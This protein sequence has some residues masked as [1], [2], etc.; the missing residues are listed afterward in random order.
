MGSGRAAGSEVADDRTGETVPPPFL[1]VTTVQEVVERRPPPRFTPPVLL[2]PMTSYPGE[3]Y[4]VVLD[5]TAISPEI[6]TLAAE[7]TVVV[8]L[9]VLADGS[10]GRSEVV[11]SSGHPV[12]DQAAL[13]ASL[14]WRF[15]PATRDGRP[16]DAW[17]IVPVRFVVP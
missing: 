17:A 11:S 5:R 4:A 13:S 8:R 12:L 2:T 10:V 7:G 1:Q 3:G 14:G 6:R 16:I 9:L 15:R